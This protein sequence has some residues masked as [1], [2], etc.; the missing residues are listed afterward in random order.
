MTF[1]IELNRL[2]IA[3]G[4][5]EQ[6]LRFLKKAGGID[7]TS[8][9]YEALV[10]TAITLYARPFSKNEVDPQAKANKCVSSEVLDEYTKEERV[11]HDRLLEVRNKAIAHAEWNNYPTSVSWD[12]RVIKSRRYSIYPE[13]ITVESFA[14]LAMKLERRLQNMRVDRVL[15]ER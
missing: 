10:M 6:A 15:Q 1:D 7:P 3:R 2:T 8:D 4:D 5:I 9:E 13:F 12:T 14:A 11:L